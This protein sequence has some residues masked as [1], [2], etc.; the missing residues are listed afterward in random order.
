MKYA[1]VQKYYDDGNIMI[2]VRPA[3]KGEQWSHVVNNDHDKW[4]NIFDSK[5]EAEEYGRSKLV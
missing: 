4:I 5:N 2:S 1:C 3:I